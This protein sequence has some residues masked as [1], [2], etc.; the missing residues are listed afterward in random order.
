M[1]TVN[2]RTRIFVAVLA[3][4]SMLVHSGG[5]TSS[6]VGVATGGTLLILGLWTAFRAATVGGFLIAVGVSAFFTDLETMTDAQ[7]LLFA[8]VAILIP[9]IALGWAALTAED[10]HQHTLRLRNR[11]ALVATGFAASCILSV[12]AAMVLA[13]VLAP[14]TAFEASTMLEIAIILVFAMVPT[15]YLFTLEPGKAGTGEEALEAE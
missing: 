15:I 9:A 11:Q 5:E 4:G 12:P 7:N 6:L 13:R 14:S 8:S 3:I 10:E 2:V 1:T